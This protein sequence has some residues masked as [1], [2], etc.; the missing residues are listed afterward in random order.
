LL[1]PPLLQPEKKGATRRIKPG[2]ITHFCCF[3]FSNSSS[4]PDGQTY[5]N[6]MFANTYNSMGPKVERLSLAN[7]PPFGEDAAGRPH[8]KKQ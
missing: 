1:P 2:V 7:N 6:S 3:I 8:M 5:S 4:K